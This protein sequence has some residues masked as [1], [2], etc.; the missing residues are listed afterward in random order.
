[1]RFDDNSNW[2]GVEIPEQ[3]NITKEEAEKIF[4]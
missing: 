2:K 3:K 4:E 1:M